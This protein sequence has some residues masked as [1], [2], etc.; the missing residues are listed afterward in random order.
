[1]KKAILYVHGKGGNAQEGESYRRNC[2]GFPIYG[3][4]YR[5]YLPWIAGEDILADYEKLRQEY[6]AIYLVAN[7]IGAF[8]AML[9]LQ[10]CKLEKALLI[11]PIL[12]MERLITDM[13]G[14]ANVTEE[15]LRIQGEIGTN[16]GE[17]LSWEYLQYVRRNPIHWDVPTE[18]LY[19]GQDNLTSRQTVEEFVSAHNAG[20]TV[21]EAGEH[22]FHTQEQLDFLNAW[23]QKVI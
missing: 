20:L 21:M 17:T 2:P 18:I 9:A 15:E 22:W 5:E 13:M 1:M 10:E 4:D 11:S 19:A 6:D 16:F 14:W 12:N 8:F 23:I 3:V 7:S